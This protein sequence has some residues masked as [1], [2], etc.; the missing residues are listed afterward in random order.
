MIVNITPIEGDD[1]V[2]IT[3]LNSMIA[4]LSADGNPR[5]VYVSR[6]NKWFEHKWLR[7]SGIGRVRFDS[8]NPEKDTAL[9]EFWQSHL[10]FPPF[11]PRQVSAPIAWRLGLAGR[12]E[13]VSKPRLFAKPDRR[14]SA[15][16]LHHRVRSF[17]ESALFV[18]FSSYS[19]LN[20]MASL[21]AYSVKDDNEGAWYASFRKE[22]AWHVAATKGIP[23]ERL[24]QLFPLS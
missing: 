1:K 23:R 14:H 20:G 12:Y 17:A 9:N 8:Y 21:M 3:C 19:E 6:V 4:Q 11:S 24:L 2:F 15:D 5:E 10:T 16:N 7:F 22:P 18:W 13:Q